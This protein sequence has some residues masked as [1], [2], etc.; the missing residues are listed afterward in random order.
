MKVEFQKVLPLLMGV[1]FLAPLFCFGQSLFVKAKIDGV[2]NRKAFLYV[3]DSRNQDKLLDSTLAVNDQ[4][5]FTHNPEELNLYTITVDSVPGG[6]L[7]ILDSNVQI[8]GNSKAIWEASI[9]GSPLT[10]EQ[11]R[12][13]REFVFSVRQK[14]Y[15]ISDSLQDPNLD[16]ATREEL[17]FQQNKILDAHYLQTEQYIK[18]HPDSF[19]SLSLL[20]SLGKSKKRELV[21]LLSQELQEHSI[22]KAIREDLRLE[23]SVS[24]GKPAPGFTVQDMKGNQVTLSDYWGQYV[25][26]DFWGSWCGP[27]LKLIPE[28]K[29]AYEKY[30]GKRVQFISVALD[31]EEDRA[32]LSGLIEK[33]DLSWPQIFQDMSDK[34]KSGVVD[35]YLVSAFPSIILINPKGEI[36]YRGTGKFGLVEAKELLDKEID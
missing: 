26:L 23:E 18:E 2:G 13:E 6:I 25:L 31:E 35:K 7:F 4:F 12:Y 11:Q 33:H 19:K 5:V 10:D 1:L 20:H 17:I 9:M 21:G 8:E 16:P 24:V 22:A 36:I 34:S 15:A 32:T 27:C 28:T 3:R 30:K 29:A 14:I